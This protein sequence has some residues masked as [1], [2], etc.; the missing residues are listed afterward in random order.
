MILEQHYLGCLVPGLLPDR[1]RGQRPGRRGGPA[2]RRRAVPGARPGPGPVDPARAP[3]PFPR[4]LRGRAPRAGGTHR[5]H[6]PPGGRGRGRV[7]PRHPW[8]DGQ[9][10]SLGR[11]RLRALATPGHT[12]ES[13]CYL[14]FDDDDDA[15]RPHAVLTGRHAVHRRRGAARPDVLGGGDRRGAGGHALR[16]PAA[17]A[18]AAAGTRPWS[19]PATAR[20]RCAARTS[21]PRPS[22]RWGIKKRFNYALQDMEREAFVALV[23]A[24]QPTAPRYFGFRRPAEPPPARLP[25]GRP[26]GPWCPWTWRR[27]RPPR[28]RARRWWTCATRRTSPPGTWR[29]A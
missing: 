25:G 22:P 6:D 18:D 3:D 21:A 15:E 4:R 13:T 1:R 8:A 17:E 16:L 2:A 7:P 5:R 9:E 20:A 14:V 29:A 11:V 24:G 26:W 23:A 19:T 12:P 28:P 10:L 27:C